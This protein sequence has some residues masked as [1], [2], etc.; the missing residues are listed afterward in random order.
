MVKALPI[1]TIAAALRFSWRSALKHLPFFIKLALLLLALFAGE[2]YISERLHLLNAKTKYILLVCN[3]TFFTLVLHRLVDLG[4][5]HAAIDFSRERQP[6]WEKVL[7]SLYLIGRYLLAYLLYTG[8]MILGGLFFIVPGAYV[9]LKYGFMPYLLV[10]QKVSIR[11]AFRQSSILRKGYMWQICGWELVL[12]GLNLLAAM[13]FALV[14]WQI[15]RVDQQGPT[16]W[17][18]ILC[19][20]LAAGLLLTLPMTIIGKAYVY[21]QFY[22]QRYLQLIKR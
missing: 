6:T 22:R 17:Q 8:L 15:S 12:I 21:E 18:I 4:V 20:P 1:F 9:A 10:D 3:F 14:L 11:E 5:I 19:S 13:P 2:T 16:L 7:T